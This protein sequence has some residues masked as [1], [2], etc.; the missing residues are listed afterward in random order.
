MSHTRLTSDLHTPHHERHQ[1]IR[2]LLVSAVLTVFLWQI[3][4]GN[5]L[6]YPFTILST[7]FHEMGHGLSA[8]V[9]GG[10]FHQL[11]IFANG[12]GIATHSGGFFFS[13]PFVAAG[14]LLGPPLA[15]SFFILAGA[16]SRLSRWVLVALGAALLLSTLIWVRTV[17][18]WV[19]LPLLGLA[20]VTLARRASDGLA[21]MGVQFL[22]VQA[23]IGTFRQLDYLFMNRIQ[24]GGRAMYSD[25]G[26]IAQS[27]LLP[28]WVWGS[29]IAA[30]SCILLLTSIR[31]AY[32]KKA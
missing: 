29:V 1:A 26:Q 11:L 24:I 4:F 18:G 15:G 31:L 30:L 21:Q 3:P 8:L 2:W 10:R 9:L 28:Y 25:T 14:G 6:L 20:L 7:W 5:Y 23:C 19:I 16:R 12:S 27:L 22:G 17:F 32:G 13:Q